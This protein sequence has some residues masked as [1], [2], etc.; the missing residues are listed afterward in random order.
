MRFVNMDEII[1]ILRKEFHYID[2]EEKTVIEILNNKNNF[3]IERRDEQN[4][5]I[6]VSIINKNTILFFYVDKDYRNKGIGTNLLKESE[7]YIKNNGYKNIIIGVGYNYLMPGVPTSKKYYDSVNECLVKDVNDNASN[8]FEKRGYFHSWDCNCFDMKMKLNDF[9]RFENSIN[10]TIKNVKYRWAKLSDLEEVIDCA[11]D[12]CQYQNTKFSKY[13]KNKEFYQ[14]TNNKRI[15]VAERNNKIIGCIIV[16]VETEAKDLGNVGCTCV[17]YSETHQGIGANMVILGTQH[18]YNIGLK[19]AGLAYT[20]SGLDKMYGKA[21]YK[22]S[23]YYMMAVK[24][25]NL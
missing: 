9:N 19:N 8:F 15:L 20:Y 4:K 18:L 12:A 2:R 22:I 7:N 11:D 23:C 17:R 10:D 1:K 21:G 5:L 16:S 3:F 14:E 25:L 6:A 13:Y 24:E